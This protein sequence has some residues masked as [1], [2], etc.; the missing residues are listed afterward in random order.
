MNNFKLRIAGGLC[1]CILGIQSVGAFSP[2]PETSFEDWDAGLEFRGK[3]G[4]KLF[5]HQVDIFNIEPAPQNKNLPVPYPLSAAIYLFPDREMAK[6]SSGEY[7]VR[8]QKY[9]LTIL[10]FPFH[11]FW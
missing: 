3:S 10:V 11:F 8:D 9:G 5:F 4:L 6:I 1:L 2:A 7:A